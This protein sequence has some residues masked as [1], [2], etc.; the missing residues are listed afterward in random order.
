ML[1]LEREYIDVRQFSIL[2]L[3]DKIRPETRRR[4]KIQPTR[5]ASEPFSRIRGYF[6]LIN[7]SLTKNNQF[8]NYIKYLK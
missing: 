8:E 2:I 7:I 4:R 3:K 6:I 1:L 5:Y